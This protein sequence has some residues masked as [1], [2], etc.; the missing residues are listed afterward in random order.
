MNFQYLTKET[1]TERIVPTEEN[2][3]IC[4]L[5]RIQVT[6]PRQSRTHRYSAY[7]AFAPSRNERDARLGEFAHVRN[8]T[9]ASAVP[10]LC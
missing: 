10:R 4:R 7:R 5:S 3:A 1:R 2:G 8:F 9:M 6:Q